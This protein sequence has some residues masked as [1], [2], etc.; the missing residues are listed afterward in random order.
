MQ[1]LIIQD[2]LRVVAETIPHTPSSALLEKLDVSLIEPEIAPPMSPLSPTSSAVLSPTI[3]QTEI[4]TSTA[5]PPPPPPG[6]IGRADRFYGVTPPNAP[7]LSI[8]QRPHD[9][10]PF[11]T[12]FEDAMAICSGPFVKLGASL[13]TSLLVRLKDKSNTS[14]T[15]GWEPELWIKN[16]MQELQKV[17]KLHFAFLS[18]VAK[19]NI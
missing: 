13:M 16:T 5:P 7:G 14:V 12:L 19:F 2:T 4:E 17:S 3:E 9:T 11:S 1:P 10:V 6:A 15:V 8:S 18:P